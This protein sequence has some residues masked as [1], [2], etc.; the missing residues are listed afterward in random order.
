MLK[1]SPECTPEIRQVENVP[2]K[3]VKEEEVSPTQKK[4]PKS[5]PWLVHTKFLKKVEG[6]D[7]VYVKKELEEVFMEE[8]EE[9]EIKKRTEMKMFHESLLG[10]K[11]P[12][13]ESV[14]TE[15]KMP[16]QVFGKVIS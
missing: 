3:T 8:M 12:S 11:A 7:N 5:E 2:K 9:K 10:S 15:E 14:N 6:K 1:I 16:D 13:N 4:K